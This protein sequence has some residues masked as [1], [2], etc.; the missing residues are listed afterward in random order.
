MGKRVAIGLCGIEGTV[1]SHVVARQ[2]DRTVFRSRWRLFHRFGLFELFPH[3]EQ[4]PKLFVVHNEI[5][6]YG[7]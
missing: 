2:P 3:K 1:E 7:F 5:F 6:R 4:T